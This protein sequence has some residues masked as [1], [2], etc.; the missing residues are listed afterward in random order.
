MTAHFEPVTK[1]VF[2]WK[3]IADNV[4]AAYDFTAQCIGYLAVFRLV[5]WHHWLG[6]T[7]DFRVIAGCGC[8]L[9]CFVLLLIL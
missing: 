7:H 2:L 5:C 3:R 1:I 9:Y 6:D 8:G 4:T